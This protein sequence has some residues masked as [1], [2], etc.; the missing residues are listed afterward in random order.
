MFIYISIFLSRLTDLKTSLLESRRSS[1]P[2]P[3]SSNRH[4]PR[5]PV[6]KHSNHLEPRLDVQ[7]LD[8]QLHKHFSAIRLNFPSYIFLYF[9]Q[10]FLKKSSER[11]RERKI[12]RILFFSKNIVF[13]KC[14]DFFSLYQGG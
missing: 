6:T 4:S 7:F 11:K 12:S 1:R 10:I 2:S 13:E 3:R 5:C 8:I 14:F 9:T